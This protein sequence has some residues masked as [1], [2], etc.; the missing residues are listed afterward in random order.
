MPTEALRPGLSFDGGYST[1][2][3]TAAA[4]ARANMINTDGWS[5][6][7]GG[8]D[9][10]GQT[11]PPTVATNSASSVSASGARLNGTADPNGTSTSAW[12]EWGTTTAYGN[13]TAPKSN[14]GSGTAVVAYYFDLA[15]LQCGSTYHFRAAAQ[16]AGGVDYGADWTF[17]AAPCE[18]DD[19]IFGAGFEPQ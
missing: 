1:Y 18:L 5:I 7:D 8:Q 13:A 19:V 3:S 12:F 2:C 4:N 14:L 15:A 10:S 16:N 11:T 6:S 17:T 9:C